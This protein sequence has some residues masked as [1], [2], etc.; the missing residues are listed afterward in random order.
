MNTN[1]NALRQANPLECRADIGQQIETGAA[2]VLGDTPA[3]AIH[4]GFDRFVRIGH[5]G[6]DGPVARADSPDVVF[7]EKPIN[8]E[9]V[10]IHQG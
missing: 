6:N 10:D 5:Q 3:Y 8:P 9:A 2:I 1:R 7:L 4:V